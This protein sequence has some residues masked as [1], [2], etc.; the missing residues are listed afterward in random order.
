MLLSC[1]RLVFTKTQMYFQCMAGTSI[2]S[3]TPIFRSD[4]RSSRHTHSMWAINV[5]DLYGVFPRDTIRFDPD[6]IN[7]RLCEYYKRQLSF[8]TDTIDAFLGVLNFYRALMPMGQ[9]ITQFYGVLF[10]YSEHPKSELPRVSFLEGLLWLIK[11]PGD[12]DKLLLCEDTP[13]VVPHTF[14]SWSWASVKAS[15]SA[16]GLGD[17]VP[18]PIS[19]WPCDCKKYRGIEVRVQH[20]HR[21]IR[22]LADLHYDEDNYKYF[23]PWIDITTWTRPCK[24]LQSSLR[25]GV[26]SPYRSD[27]TI[28]DPVAVEK[29]EV[30]AICLKAMSSYY[31]DRTILVSGLLVVETEPGVYRRV[32]NFSWRIDSHFCRLTDEFDEALQHAFDCDDGSGAGEA[33][34]WK[35]LAEDVWNGPHVLE[36]LR[37]DPWQRRTMRLI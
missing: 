22:R 4:S 20:R 13:Y 28:H 30:H 31:S 9:K 33:Q 24:V 21:G 10:S 1:R 29:M 35:G 32:A 12:D 19:R 16:G 17:L 37:E 34:M 3:L 14:P 27:S 23:M 36:R 11:Y 5:D 26:V 7:H 2:E 15:Q 6:H 25:V 18:K 8:C